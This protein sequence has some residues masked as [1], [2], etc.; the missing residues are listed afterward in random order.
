MRNVYCNKLGTHTHTDT[1]TNRTS[2]IEIYFFPLMQI[3]DF[4][5]YVI[6]RALNWCGLGV[7]RISTIKLNQS[8]CSW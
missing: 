2:D 3:V 5:K 1:H 6:E 4:N 7:R 8:I